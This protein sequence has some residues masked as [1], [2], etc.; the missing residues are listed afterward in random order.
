MS[1]YYLMS[2]RL[3]DMVQIR[4]QLDVVTFCTPQKRPSTDA[5]K[6]TDLKLFLLSLW[7]YRDIGLHQCDQIL[8]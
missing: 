3:T 6:N 4:N 8:K 1:N 5:Q 7:E 2:F